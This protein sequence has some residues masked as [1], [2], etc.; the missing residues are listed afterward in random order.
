MTGACPVE[1]P[2]DWQEPSLI[3]DGGA[4]VVERL[5]SKHEALS[6]HSE[7]MATDINL[8]SPSAY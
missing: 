5:S 7:Y 1:L 3:L 8:C 6:S 4:Q 2:G